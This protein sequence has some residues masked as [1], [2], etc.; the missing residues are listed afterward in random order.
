[1]GPASWHIPPAIK[2]CSLFLLPLNLPQ[3]LFQLSLNQHNGW[4]EAEPNGGDR[5]E[6]L[7][8]CSQQGGF[9]RQAPQEEA[10][11]VALC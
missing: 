5:G 7:C 9:A 1:M 8:N 2:G 11:A 10:E 3:L 4:T 6:G